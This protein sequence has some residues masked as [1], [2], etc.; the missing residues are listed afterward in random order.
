MLFTHAQGYTRR[1]SLDTA[2]TRSG[3]TTGCTGVLQ[4]DDVERIIL[5]SPDVPVLHDGCCPAGGTIVQN[6]WIKR[7]SSLVSM[8]DITFGYGAQIPARPVW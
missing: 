5:T 1:L 6:R 2:T 4:G 3:F 8:T 7:V